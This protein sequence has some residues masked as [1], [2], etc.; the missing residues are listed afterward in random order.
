MYIIFSMNETAFMYSYIRTDL[1]PADALTRESWT[2]LE[3]IKEPHAGQPTPAR[4]R[5]QTTLAAVTI[6]P[7]NSKP[8]ESPRF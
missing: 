3:E 7:H 5:P 2:D 6:H 4:V 1:N 8:Q